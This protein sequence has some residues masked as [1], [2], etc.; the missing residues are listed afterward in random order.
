M[1]ANQFP[2]LE[3]QI[4]WQKCHAPYLRLQSPV[5]MV[6]FH[7][8]TLR[9]RFILGR[10]VSMLRDWDFTHGVLSSSFISR[11]SNYLDIYLSAHRKPDFSHLRPSSLLEE[12]DSSSTDQYF[13][14]K[15]PGCILGRWDFVP[16]W[17]GSIPGGPGDMPWGLGSNLQGQVPSLERGISHRLP[18]HAW[19]S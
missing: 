2:C 3:N 15:I 19:K 13:L 18:W 12:P 5:C 6:M 7:A 14:L 11:V 8:W 17:L 1:L 4:L 9:L 10:L 16:S